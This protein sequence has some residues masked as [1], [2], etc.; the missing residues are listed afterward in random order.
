MS[1]AVFQSDRAVNTFGLSTLKPLRGRCFVCQGK[2]PNKPAT[3]KLSGSFLG[4]ASSKTSSGGFGLSQLIHTEDYPEC[5]NLERIAE[6]HE[7]IS[8]YQMPEYYKGRR[9]T[10]S[11]K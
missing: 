8:E 1:C 4:R 9:N 7:R 5:P 2:K 6:N 11:T 10:V 3:K